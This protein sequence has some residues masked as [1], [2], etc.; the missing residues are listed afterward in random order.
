[1]G[2]SRETAGPVVLD[3]GKV[4]RVT[5]KCFGTFT[6][7]AVEP[8]PGWCG[9]CILEASEQLTREGFAVGEYIELTADFYKARPL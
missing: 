6:A 4:Y 8:S 2:P 5:H 1:M 7:R 3:V 9:F